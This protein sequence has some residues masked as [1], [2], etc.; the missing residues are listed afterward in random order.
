ML[1]NNKSVFS[2]TDHYERIGEPTGDD[3]DHIHN[4]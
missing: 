1:K 3:G 2:E 4:Q